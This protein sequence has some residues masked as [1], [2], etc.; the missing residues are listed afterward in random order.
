MPI[1]FVCENY[2]QYEII[3][4]LHK[5]IFGA[6]IMFC[7]KPKI[8]TW[9]G[10]LLG[11]DENSVRN[12]IFRLIWDT[13]VFEIVK[14]SHNLSFQRGGESALPNWAVSDLILYS[15]FETQVV[16]I[17]RLL[18]NRSDVISLKRLVKDIRKSHRC[19]TRKN[20][21]DVLGLPYDYEDGLADAH[22]SNNPSEFIRCANSENMHK[23]IDLLVGVLAAGQRKP[24]DTVRECVLDWIEKR[25]EIIELEDIRKYRNKFVAHAA[26][27]ESRKWKNTDDFK[28][29]LGK[30]SEAHKIIC[31][32]SAFIAENILGK[33]IQQ[34]FARS[35][36]DVLENLDK[37][38]A[39]QEDISL[40]REQWKKYEKNT[41]EWGNW[42]WASD[43]VG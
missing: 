6:S 16:A 9:K 30:I 22:T 5:T 35:S 23:R 37:P 38:L 31:E 40:L 29:S 20:M 10:W 42:N 28:I 19:L 4:A 36:R 11:D 13:A 26:T 32:T 39:A 7:L 41:E 33:S 1:H 34:F 21:L 15:Y 2:I 3:I 12:Q 17:V 14:T 27:A 18:D 8:E 24:T 43:F 25:L